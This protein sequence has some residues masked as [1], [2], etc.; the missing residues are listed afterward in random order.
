MGKNNNNKTKEKYI[1]KGVH[2]KKF[3]IEG[4][5]SQLSAQYYKVCF[6]NNNQ[7]NRKNHIN[8]NLDL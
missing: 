2:R 7:Y 3:A 1:I 6:N 5:K 8:A 4:N